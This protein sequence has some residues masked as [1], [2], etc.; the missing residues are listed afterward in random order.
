MKFFR[1]LARRAG[2]AGAIVMLAG[3]IFGYGHFMTPRSPDAF[4]RVF[5]DLSGVL[6]SDGMPAYMN[7]SVAEGTVQ[8]VYL[9][10]N[11]LHYTLNRT[12]KGID[13]LLDFYEN[14]YQS[15]THEVAPKA[16]REALLATVR[17]PQDREEQRRRIIATDE[18]LNDRFVRF[19]GKDWGGFSTLVTGR[20]GEANYMADMVERFRS[21]QNSGDATDLGDP[22]LL[23]AFEDAS[24][25]DVQYFNVWPAGGFDFR[26]VKP[27]GKDDAAG[28]DLSDIPRPYG[29]QRMITFGQNHMG[30]DYQILLYRGGGS[31]EEIAA[32]FVTAMGDEGWAA[33]A[34]Y[35]RAH[36]AMDGEFPSLLFTKGQREA[37]VALTQRDDDPVV[38]S[39]VV[40]VGRRG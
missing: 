16:A 38:S 31:V 3:A 32:H 26:S 18:L 15:R 36:G 14:L 1:Y 33:S 17:D 39:T 40:V 23:V 9:N 10:G 35:L 19:E 4:A 30:S 8:E 29:S 34:T 11:T 2:R 6:N 25:G 24:E 5:E 13:D 20:E 28:Y 27:Q 12:N 21:F 7:M 22:K 37:Y